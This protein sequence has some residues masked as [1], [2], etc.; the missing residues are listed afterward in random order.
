MP[1]MSGVVSL[2]L[3][4]AIQFA[5]AN[6]GELR[7]TV[8]DASGLLLKSAVEV[9]SEANQFRQK[10]ETDEL[11]LLVARRL[12]FG[13]YQVSVARDGFAT[14][15]R[16][17]E[18]RSAVPAEFRVSVDV[19]GPDARVVVTAA[20]SLVDLSEATVVNRIG[21][22]TLR[23]RTTA[24][25][26][27]SLPDLVN[28]QPGW[29]LEANGILHPRASE[30]QTQFVVDGVPFTDNRSPAFAPEVAT[31]EVRAVQIRTGGYPAE[32]GRKL[33][34]V[35]EIV[36]TGQPRDGWHG[37]ASSSVGSF[38]TLSGNATAN[39]GWAGATLGLSAGGAATDWFLDPPVEQ[40]YTNHGTTSQA[41][42]R[43]ERDFTDSD[44]LGL[45][46]RYGGAAFQV[47]NEQVQQDAGQRQDR[48]T[49][50]TAAQV[51]Y[52]RIV[53]GNAVFDLR[54]MARDLSAGLR[55]NED[56]TPVIATQDRGLR[57]GYLKATVS[58]HLGSHEI[59]AGGDLTIGRIREA[60]AYTLTDAGA[61][62]P[63]T[64]PAFFF[65]GEQTSSEQ[66]LFVQDQLR[67]GSW[68]V[69]AGLRWDRYDL[70]VTE[71][72][73]SPRL[74][75]A[76]SWPGAALVVRA[77]YDRAFQTP[78]FE[79]LLLASSPSAGDLNDAV[80]Q[81]P[82]RPSLGNFFETG[83][84]KGLFGRLRLDA[85]VFSRSMSHA[86]DDDLLLNTGVSFP[87][88]FRRVEVAGAE[89]KLETP[90]WKRVSGYLSYGFMRAFADLPATGGLF[91]G[92]EGNEVL[93]SD[94]R[95][96]SSQ[97]QRHT[98]RGRVAYQ[99]GSRGW[100]ALAGAYGSGLPFEDVEGD[101]ADA[102]AQFGQSVVDR[103]DFA[104]GRVKASWSF[105]ASAGVV[106][107]KTAGSSLRLQ[108]EVRN[109]TNRLNLI[110]YAGLFSGTAI[111]PPRGI[112]IRLGADF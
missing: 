92:N 59:K 94:E 70:V 6:T 2:L 95:L 84:S 55:S 37:S 40:N 85:T 22:G 43:F 111:A 28:S 91:L 15:V 103:V 76:W 99:L 67:I 93:E 20:Q 47:P 33:G 66:S 53:S 75:A 5:P 32:Y 73:F 110:N 68:T 101:E 87:I 35:I 8:T 74:A 64:P 48:D 13:S 77:S 10:F 62:D 52:Q 69:S 102:A 34:G 3:L 79:N 11:G 24:L 21:A 42:V 60:F 4:C 83:I 7:L 106:L 18:I 19:A 39:Y 107:A 90:E 46:A 1:C 63:G 54:G 105:D 44:R 41:A 89:L 61:F 12:P 81:L 86:A 109:L 98:V 104:S 51:S 78:A 45:S 49:G 29:L 27:R 50:E 30:Y 100:V 65:S 25:P 38:N 56:S 82:V 58:A 26:G 112:A 57:E 36:T 88:A 17:V 31:D 96:P 80:R 16:V 72:A 14:T 71:H 97:D 23:Q 9:V 108:V